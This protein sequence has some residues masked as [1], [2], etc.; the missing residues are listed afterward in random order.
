[1]PIS[2]NWH[3]VWSKFYFNKKNFGTFKAFKECFPSYI[4]SIIKLLFYM[5]IKNN[6]KKKIYLNRA[7]GFYNSFIGKPSWYRP[8]LT[9]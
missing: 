4:S 6:Y 1:M 5:L 3:W 7:S 9:D 2:R 8:K